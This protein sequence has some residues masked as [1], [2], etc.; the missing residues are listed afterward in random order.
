M[1]SAQLVSKCG[2]FAVTIP[3]TIVLQLKPLSVLEPFIRVGFIIGTYCC[4]CCWCCCCCC[5][6]SLLALAK[7]LH[8][9]VLM[10][11]DIVQGLIRL[12]SLKEA[13]V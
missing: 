13:N 4:L 5:L 8:V 11:G 2:T 12:S 1:Y 3:A 10:N 6:L 7:V 9:F